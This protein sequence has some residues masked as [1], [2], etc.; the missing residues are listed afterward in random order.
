MVP[1]SKQLLAR[2]TTLFTVADDG[3][4]APQE[5]GRELPETG[6]VVRSDFAGSDRDL[7][8][9]ERVASWLETPN[10]AFGYRCPAEYLQSSDSGKLRH[11][12]AVIGSLEDGAFS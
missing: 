2:L 10:P 6:S 1:T 3:A 5:L 4:V 11:L 8:V 9:D 12:E 7:S